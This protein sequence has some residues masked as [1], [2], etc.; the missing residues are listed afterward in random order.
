MIGGQ[1]QE[2]QYS[3][4]HM[5]DGQY[6]ITDRQTVKQPA[7]RQTYKGQTERRQAAN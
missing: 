4:R 2:V 1:R 5:T 6:S 7:D 3:D